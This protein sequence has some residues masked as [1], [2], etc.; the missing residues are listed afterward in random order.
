MVT[1]R[2][3]HHKPALIYLMNRSHAKISYIVK[4]A[5]MLTRKSYVYYKV[6]VTYSLSSIS[7]H[8]TFPMASAHDRVA[9]PPSQAMEG[10]RIPFRRSP[11]SFGVAPLFNASVTNEHIASSCALAQP[12][13]FSRFAITK[14]FSLGV[15]LYVI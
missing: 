11:T 14:G 5:I 12:P 3:N 6:V 13:A 2:G 4:F 15:L 8:N 10:Q 9:C 1:W 7:A